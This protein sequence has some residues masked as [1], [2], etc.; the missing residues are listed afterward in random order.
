MIGLV[1]WGVGAANKK[2]G[3]LPLCTHLCSCSPPCLCTLVP[4]PSC[5][6]CW[7]LVH[8][9]LICVGHLFT[10]TGPCSCSP[11]CLCTPALHTPSCWRRWHLA[12]PHLFA[13]PPVCAHQTLFSLSPVYFRTCEVINIR[14]LVD[15]LTFHL[16][17]LHLTNGI[18][19]VK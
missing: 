16:C 17:P 3:G 14:I 13:W 7:P 18:C 5:W 6:P 10:H 2:L 19:I 4:P 12:C 1:G 9:A 15:L 8:A 11:P